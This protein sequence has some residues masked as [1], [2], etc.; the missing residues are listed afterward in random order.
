[1]P[2][3]ASILALTALLGCGASTEGN[4]MEPRAIRSTELPPP[5]DGDIA[6]REELDAARA[7]GTVAAYDAFL[8]RHP[9]HRLARSARR[10]RARIA[11]ES[12]Q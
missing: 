2:A 1:M 4:V 11:A 6:V 3:R 7:A 5:R 8:A 12:S 9:D 10:E